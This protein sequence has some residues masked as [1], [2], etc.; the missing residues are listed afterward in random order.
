LLI[1]KN[2]YEK[3]PEVVPSTLGAFFVLYV[4]YVY[5]IL[6]VGICGEVT[7]LAVKTNCSQMP[8][9]DLPKGGFFDYNLNKKLVQKPITIT[10]IID[11]AVPI[12]KIINR[13]LLLW[14]PPY[15]PLKLPTTF[16][17]NQTPK[18]ATNCDGK[19]NHT[20]HKRS[21]STHPKCLGKK[22]NFSSSLGIE[23]LPL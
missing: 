12:R 7:S 18:K 3:D 15:Q 13:A 9:K 22:Y 11:R 16:T 21:L 6:Q 5:N 14:L 17:A 10:E 2:T 1:C 23:T 20:N 8:L 19:R 4:F